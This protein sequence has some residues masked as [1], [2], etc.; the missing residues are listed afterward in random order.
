MSGCLGAGLAVFSS[1]WLS[2]FSSSSSRLLKWFLFLQ[3][4]VNDKYYVSGNRSWEKRTLHE[5]YDI[6]GC[7][8]EGYPFLVCYMGHT[9]KACC[10]MNFKIAWFI[11]LVMGCLKSEKL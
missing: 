10:E 7:E 6:G 2:D 3:P 4:V 1:Y 5:N 9:E 8:R 11:S